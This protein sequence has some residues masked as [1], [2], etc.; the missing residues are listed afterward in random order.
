MSFI[1]YNEEEHIN[2]RYAADVRPE[3][4]DH[5]FYCPNPKCNCKFT[6]SA[7]NSNKIRTH[8]VKLP[9]SDH[10]ERCWYNVVLTDTGDKENYDTSDFSPESLLNNI[11]KSEG[12]R[13]FVK[14]RSIYSVARSADEEKRQLYIHTIRQLYAICIENDDDDKIN[15]IMV[16]YI[17][18]GRK[19]SYLYTKYISGIKLVECSYYSYDSEKNFIRFRFPYEGNHFM[20]LVYFETKD[21]FKEMRKQLYEYKQPVLIY[22]SWNNNQTTIKTKTQIVPL[23]AR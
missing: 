12:R 14:K 10:V 15:G 9:S 23:K 21:L 11:Q 16:K 20:L 8:F 7:F 4:Q 19:T 13:G 17:L 6:V 2:K 5:I 3:E 22:A 18:A 1:A